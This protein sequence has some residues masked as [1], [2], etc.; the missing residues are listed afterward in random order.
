MGSATSWLH[1]AKAMETAK[2]N[3]A[4]TV[5]YGVFVL[6][7]SFLIS[8]TRPDTSKNCLKHALVRQY[9]NYYQYGKQEHDRKKCDFTLR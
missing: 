3:N 8:E 1:P 4:T 5:T 9:A 6:S 7:S 2:E